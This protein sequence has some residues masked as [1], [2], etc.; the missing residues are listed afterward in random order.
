MPPNEATIDII[1]TKILV[2]SQEA[3]RALHNFD[4]GVHETTTNLEKIAQ[5][6]LFVRRIT[7]KAIKEMVA[8]FQKLNAPKGGG[9]FGSLGVND[10]QIAKAGKLVE[11]YEKQLAVQTKSVAETN[12][13]AIAEERVAKA[14]EKASQAEARKAALPQNAI[15]AFVKQQFGDINSYI[16]QSSNKIEAWKGVVTQSARAAGV[17]FEAAGAQLKKMVSGTTVAPLNT[18]LKQLGVDGRSAF[19]KLIDGAHLARIAIGA[20]VSMLLFQAIQAFQTMVATAVNNLR[21]L[22]VTFYRLSNVEKQLSEQGIEISFKGLKQGIEDVQKILPIFSKQEIAEMLGGLANTTKELGYSEEQLV[23]L[24]KAI[25]ILNVQS[26]DTESLLQTQSKVTTSLLTSQARG[27]ANLG[28]SFSRVT[29]TAKALQLGIIETGE[30]IE[31]LTDKQKAQVKYAIIM[32]VTGLD[33]V[34]NTFDELGNYL[35]TTDAKMLELKA[36]WSDALTD[37][38][39]RLAPFLIEAL[40]GAIDMVER[41]SAAWE[42]NKEALKRVVAVFAGLQRIANDMNDAAT[43]QSWFEKMIARLM[44]A[45]GVLLK[46]N[47]I[48]IG[49][50][51]TEGFDDAIE[52]ADKFGTAAETATGQLAGLLDEDGDVTQ[53]A[54]DDL[55]QKIQDIILDA[56]HAREDLEVLLGQKTEDIGIK[57]DQK[58]EDINTEY[59][60]KG[61]DAANDYAD[62]V[63]DI[64]QDA[65]NKI[66]DALA[67]SHDDQIKAEQQFHQ[68]LKELRQRFLQDLEDAL[69]ER[70]ARAVL[71]LQKQFRIDKQSL[72]DK[73]KIEQ[74]AGKD[75]LAEDLAN[76][77][78]ERQQKLEAAAIEYQR[79]LEELA[80]AKQRELEELNVWKERE[81][82]D[83]ALWH[84][85]ELAAIDLNVKQKLE[86]LLA[87]Y[88]AEGKLHEE[89]Q[90]AIQAIL[91]KYFGED[92]ALINDL[93]NFMAERFAQ[94]GAMAAQSVATLVQAGSLLNALGVPVGSVGYNPFVNAV[95][96][97]GGTL[98]KAE[99]G[100]VI[101]TR[102]T[103]AIFGERG[104]ELATFTPLGRTGRDV[105]KLFGDKSS[106][107]GG[108]NGQIVI[109]IDLSPDLEARIV[110][111]S[112]NGVAEVVLRVNRS[113]V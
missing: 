90:A 111:N 17:S 109:G 26:T 52:R 103:R 30:T 62:N 8:D 49:K 10:T 33:D 4:K 57:F 82:A 24:G 41:W 27:V 2:E 112:M 110:E 22:E 28:L 55:E 84:S 105:N 12:K 11:I 29:M 18:A 73:K 40:Q 113:K 60:Q 51:F 79:K 81:L 42:K 94:I 85:R 45:V 95:A 35:D 64:N 34:N 89:N 19:Q 7:G 71:R 92:M 32:D 80:I 108:V 50:S 37:V 39:I 65:Q 48:D 46:L 87:G 77:E 106:G 96:T 91:V 59:N 3:I 68:E 86:S 102:P 98:K 20:L 107:G 43:G 53:T 72:I 13:S 83:L 5:K 6:M 16:A 25:A 104:P 63:V 38:A 9:Q 47:D 76:I 23:M 44:P 36:T 54:L 101:A 78:R 69:H 66:E 88:I 31:K 100:S 58:T 70:D 56:Q 61:E 67:Q 74:K 99:G 75:K 15:P 93:A 97:G 14:A 1:A 21:E